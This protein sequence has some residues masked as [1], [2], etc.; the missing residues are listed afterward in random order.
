[1]TSDKP[2]LP[3][4]ALIA[5]PTASGKSALAMALARSLREDGREAL[6]VNADA[7]GV[8]RDIPILSAQPCPADQAEIPHALVGHIDA[9]A[10]CNAARWIAEARAAI[11]DATA[12]GTVP[13]IAGGTGLYIK[14]LLDGIAPVPDIDPNIRAEARALPAAIAH[15]R[16]QELDPAAAAKLRR[17]DTTRVQRA[18]EV[19]QSTGKPL[20]DWQASREGGIGDRIALTPMLLLPPR[21]WLRD[22]CDAR[23]D[24]MIAAG[25]LAEVEALL[26][27]D[28]DP[29]LPA[30]RAIGVPELSAHLRGETTL[31]TAIA[32]AQTATRQYAKRQ[33]NFFRGQFPADWPRTDAEINDDNISEIVTNLRDSLLT[34]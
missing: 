14:A 2:D 12:R 17:T 5:G 8:Y 15:L 34:G 7:S 27:R 30:M 21:D 24:A 16:L 23:F 22:R 13:L 20:S 9:A 32:L 11:A 29:D 28:L 1:M 6:I 19:V 26:A 18:L 25:A 31:E 10:N 3:A 33:Y 4:V